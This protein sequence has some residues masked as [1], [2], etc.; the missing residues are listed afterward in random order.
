MTVRERSRQVAA[1]GRQANSRGEMI[2]QGTVSV[3]SSR[4]VP[5][6]SEAD[7]PNRTAGVNRLEVAHRN[8]VVARAQV[9][10]RREVNVVR[11]ESDRTI[12]HQHVNPAG[13]KRIDDRVRIPGIV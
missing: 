9:A 7:M 4:T 12:S 3:A 1:V 8:T 6:R 11:D 2:R 10:K 5:H 13:V